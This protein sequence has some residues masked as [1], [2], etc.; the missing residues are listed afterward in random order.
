M[1]TSGD[2]EV[3]VAEGTHGHLSGTI[4][5]TCYQRRLRAGYPRITMRNIR[6]WAKQRKREAME[7]EEGALEERWDGREK[8]LR[9]IV[10][11]EGERV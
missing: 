9:V 11:C 7:S 1:Q 4:K 10:D 6:Q 8:Q 3:G 2:S 5:Q